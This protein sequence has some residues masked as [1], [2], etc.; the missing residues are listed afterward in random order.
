[1]KITTTYLRQVIKEEIDQVLYEQEAEEVAQG[2][3]DILNKEI[4][5]RPEVEKEIKENKEMSQPL[6]PLQRNLAAARADQMVTG[7]HKKNMRL[8]GGLAGTMGGGVAM[9]LA[10]I[11]GMVASL[12][13]PQIME[14]A[15]RLQ[16]QG[17]IKLGAGGFGLVVA[18]PI[19]IGAIYGA[20]KGY[21]KGKKEEEAFKKEVRK[22]AQGESEEYKKEVEK[23]LRGEPYDPNV[24]R[25]RST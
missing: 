18:A 7:Q 16:E 5:K 13:N 4:E 15:N 9:V 24:M 8:F 1:M 19:A 22:S 25:S 10:N 2:F 11:G 21:F 6:T 3:L 12:S 20:L 14:L 23:F 17:I